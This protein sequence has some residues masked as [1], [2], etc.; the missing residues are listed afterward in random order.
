MYNVDIICQVLMEGR[1]LPSRFQNLTKVEVDNLS[2]SAKTF[3]FADIIRRRYKM[4]EQNIGSEEVQNLLDKFEDVD[5][6]WNSKCVKNELQNTY[7]Q[8]LN[9]ASKWTTFITLTFSQ[10]CS[11]EVAIRY[12]R[13][14]VQ[15]LNKRVYGKHYVRYVGH[16]Y[17]NYVLGIESKLSRDVVHFHVLVDRPVDY[18]FIH[19]WWGLSC[20]HAWIEKI[21][22]N[23]KALHYV[24]K[25]ICKGGD[26]NIS[27]FLKAKF[28]LLDTMPSYW[29]ET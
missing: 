2:L 4:I 24:T 17:F 22:K 3:F 26:Q 13:R 9:D 7:Y 15:V 23:D 20:G 28:K 6:G 10:E 12:F 14:L 8:W 1:A 5:K 25:Y 29:Q 27:V 11:E 19:S 21:R 16:S 18:N